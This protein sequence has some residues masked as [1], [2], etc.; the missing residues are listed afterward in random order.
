MPVVAVSVFERYGYPEI[1]GGLVLIGPI[2]VML[3]PGMSVVETSLTSL[4][5]E[6]T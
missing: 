2:G 3:S 4:A 5:P 1:T 6:T